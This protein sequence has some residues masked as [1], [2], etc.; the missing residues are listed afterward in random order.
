[1]QPS[2]VTP[3]A[4]RSIVDLNERDV[5]TSLRESGAVLFRGFDADADTFA[6][7]SNR[8]STTFTCDPHKVVANAWNGATGVAG[9]VA[10]KITRTA[11]QARA[12]R[13]PVHDASP[14][15]FAPFSGYGLNPHNE[16]SYLPAA[17]P[18]L[19][20]FH[21]SRPSASGG[22]TILVD[23]G[24]MLERL[25]AP[26]ARFLGEKPIRYR[27]SLQTPQW[28]ATWG[29]ND[30]RGL[31]TLLDAQSGVSY[32]LAENGQLDVVFDS[33]QIF[34]RLFDG[35]EV[36]RSNMLSLQPFDSVQPAAAECTPDGERVP[37]SVLRAVLEAAQERTEVDLAAGDV[38][39]IDNT[40]VLHGRMPFADESRRIET[41]CAWLRDELRPRP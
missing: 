24:E 22:A 31:R 28:Q 10:R 2:L 35:V 7:F 26:S 39:V 17:F 33:T 18:E 5:L 36:V 15:R 20:W 25:D 27:T 34:P 19:V 32:E 23:G 37:E 3:G 16:N 40:R 1:M 9:Q 29:V 6:E 8:F 4:E 11:K 38:I 21:C 13:W 14:A 12:R 30:E 41:R